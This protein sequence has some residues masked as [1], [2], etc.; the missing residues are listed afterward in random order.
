MESKSHYRADIDGL[1]AIAV[2]GVVMFHANLGLPGGFVGVD[3]FFVISGYLI[4]KIILNDLEKG[5][6]SMLEFWERRIRRIFPALALVV[7]CCMIAGWFL[8]LPFG[9]LVLA[10][11]SIALSFFAS[12]IQFWRT[13]NYWSPAAEEQPLLHTWSLS[14]EEQFYLIVPLMI[15]A[16]YRFKRGF[17]AP[18]VIATCVLISFIVSLDWLRVDPKGAFFLLPSRAWELG[19]GSIVSFLPCLRIS[20][21]R[22]AVSICGLLG[23]LSSLFLLDSEIAFPG[24]AALPSVVGTALVIWAGATNS[25]GHVPMI[26]RGLAIKPLVAVGLISYSLYLWH[27]PFFAFYRY[28]FGQPAPAYL[29]VLF[30]VLT[31]FLSYFSWRFVEQPFR[32]KNIAATKKSLFLIFGV[33]TSVT[34]LFS[35]LVYF[36]N[37]LPF[38]VPE[39]AM[40][41]DRVDGN[42]DFVPLSKKILP[43]GGELINFGDANEKPRILV[44]GDSHAGVML[45]ALDSTCK[46][47]GL[48]GIAVIR[49]GTPP[50][51]GWTDQRMGSFEHHGALESGEAVKNLIENTDIN[52][53]FLIFRWSYYLQKTP[54]LHLS[55]AFTNGFEEAFLKTLTFLLQ[56]RCR[57]VVLQEV[58][59]FPSHVARSMALNVW[60]GSPRPSLTVQDHLNF[61]KPYEG[62]LKKIK[63]GYPE[64]TIIDPGIAFYRDGKIRFLSEDGRLLYR[65]EH[66]LTKAANEQVEGFFHKILDE[67]KR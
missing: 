33:A 24:L 50:T 11:S 27:W 36:N 22:E 18:I 38:R 3:V 2:L 47:V 32:K 23:I 62:V 10:Q 20:A 31:F 52:T 30:I 43:R 8:L 5:K 12:N 63:D 29:S 66:H 53:V 55:Q 51:F 67:R 13:I 9:Y 4:T 16:L 45:H 37:G 65:D 40:F 60:I 57:V 17:F 21:L 1:R 34:V 14:V 46:K 15:A 39:A 61:R 41:Y 42:Q 7:L 44:W 26:S 19:A 25:L 54:S 56:K 58:P 6:F 28:L 49:G 48:S 35:G 59:I 64:I